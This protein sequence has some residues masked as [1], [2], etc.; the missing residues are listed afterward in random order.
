MRLKGTDMATV[1]LNEE[2]VRAACEQ[3]ASQEEYL[4]AI[5]RMVLPDWDAIERIARWPACNEKTWEAICRLAMEAD[6]RLRLNVL[7]GG[8]WLNHGFTTGEGKN[9]A[10]WQ[11]CLDTARIIYK[12]I[13]A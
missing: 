13:A 9:L 6:Q 1:R 7:P 10:D 12:P 3:A 4:I 11:V 2:K 5:Y 8:A